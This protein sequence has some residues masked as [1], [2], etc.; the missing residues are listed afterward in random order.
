MSFADRNNPYS[1]NDFL[2]WRQGVDYYA[3]DP[4]IQKV[5]RRFTGDIWQQVDAAARAVSAKA[6]S[7]W[8]DRIVVVQLSGQVQLQK[9]L[10]S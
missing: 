10:D 9:Q 3:D 8:R 6:S 2:A 5:V 7:R 4:F 1:F